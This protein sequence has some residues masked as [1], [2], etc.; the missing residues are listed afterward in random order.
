M[1]HALVKAYMGF[2]RAAHRARRKT[3]GAE[4][5]SCFWSNDFWW[6]MIST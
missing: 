2:V 5:N 6:V 3:T 4:G 1:V